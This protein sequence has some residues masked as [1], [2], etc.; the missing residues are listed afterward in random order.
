VSTELRVELEG[1]Y[2][3]SRRD[4]LASLF[5]SLEGDGPIVVD[6]TKVSYIDSTILHELSML[7]ARDRGR[8]ITLLG[9]SANV[10]RILKVASFDRIFEIK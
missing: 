9:S 10:R 8:E 2:D 6:M 4:E 3:I 1:E 7:R 5:S